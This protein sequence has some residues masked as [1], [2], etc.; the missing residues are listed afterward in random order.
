VTS[1]PNALTIEN[2][3]VVLIDHQ[4]GVGQAVNSIDRIEGAE[5]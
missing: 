2:S 1:N 4:P 3:A 5:S